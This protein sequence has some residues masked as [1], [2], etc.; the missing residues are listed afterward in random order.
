MEY[1]DLLD[2]GIYLLAGDT[3]WAYFKIEY[4]E[5]FQTMYFHSL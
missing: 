3:L 2:S 4:I 1:C 5:N